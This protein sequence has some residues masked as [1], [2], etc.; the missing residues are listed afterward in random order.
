V[1]VAR[2]ASIFLF[3]PLLSTGRIGYPMT[4][5]T[6]LFMVWAGLRGAVSNDQAGGIY[7]QH[8]CDGSELTEPVGA[9]S[10]HNIHKACLQ[11]S[12]LFILLLLLPETACG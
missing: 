7:I 9:R 11:P 6:A 4:W 1:Q 3:Y 2:G 8:K 5:K 10:S 12:S